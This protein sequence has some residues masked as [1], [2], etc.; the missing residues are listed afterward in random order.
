MQNQFQ[1]FERHRRRQTIGLTI[2]VGLLTA[3][4]AAISIYFTYHTSHL[5]M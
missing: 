1:K 5:R 3:V 2:A 4:L